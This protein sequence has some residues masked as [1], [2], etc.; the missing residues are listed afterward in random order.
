MPLPVR[1]QK[2][3][4]IYY[5][6]AIDKIRPLVYNSCKTSYCNWLA[7]F[8]TYS[9]ISKHNCPETDLTLFVAIRPELY[10]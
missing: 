9:D 5:F 4:V 2:G 8:M 1:S 7:V 6:M 10:Y 3:H